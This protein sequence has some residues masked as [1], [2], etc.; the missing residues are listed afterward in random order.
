MSGYQV[1]TGALVAR[2][3]TVDDAAGKV[4]A[5]ASSVRGVETG[6]MPPKTAAALES[7]LA[8]WPGA[9]RRLATA[10]H[11]TGNALRASARTYEA[12]DSD[13]AGA[14]AGGHK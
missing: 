5:E 11:A 13:V 7:S 9:L 2:A 3:G 1:E 12:V 10:L 8:A 4:A 14:A 6:G